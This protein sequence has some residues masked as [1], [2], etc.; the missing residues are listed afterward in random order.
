MQLRD[1]VLPGLV[2]ELEGKFPYA[3]ALAISRRFS[4][5]RVGGA[6]TV[7]SGDQP[8]PRKNV[9]GVVFS[10]S[11]GVQFHDVYV[12]SFAQDDLASAVR[13]AMRD[14]PLSTEPHVEFDPG[15]ENVLD[16]RIPDVPDSSL[17]PA[18]DTIARLQEYRRFALAQEGIV[19]ATPVQVQTYTHEV[20]VNR[21][22][23]LA[24]YLPVL[25]LIFNL[26]AD[27]DGKSESAMVYK[28]GVCLDHCAATEE[29]IAVKAI[30]ARR[31]LDAIPKPEEIL[32]GV[33]G[34]EDF[35][36]VCAHEALGHPY[37]GDTVGHGA[38][39][40]RY[41]IGQ[42]LAAQNVTLFSDPTMIT[43]GH[44]AFDHEGQD[45]RRV[46]LLDGGVPTDA[47]LTDML[48]ARYLG[49]EQTGHGRRAGP[50]DSMYSRQSYT[51][52]QADPNGMTVDDM[53]ASIEGKGMIVYSAS[54]GMEDP[55]GLT[56]QING[57]YGAEIVKG[58]LTGRLY[59]QP[60][61]DTDVLG[62]LAAISAVGSEE[63]IKPGGCGK[64]HKEYANVGLGGPHLLLRNVRVA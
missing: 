1:E 45:A 19:S 4:R 43:T 28:G 27:R 36:G 8:A 54:S 46:I 10:V 24:Q 16:Y 20:F 59:K 52:F 47:F 32:E 58:K 60:K 64:Y 23:R 48:S 13:N 29:D 41:L 39:G 37:E 26:V 40:F 51:G 15:S 55:H 12:D 62:F 61:L 11:D 2:E 34:D 9:D 5:I 25:K 18:K 14:V 30:L 31:L 3:H 44:F 33:I 63:G 35:V 7:E 50:C 6:V 22:R 42:Q 17:V 49:V 21:N 57:A 56:L 38:A 53:I